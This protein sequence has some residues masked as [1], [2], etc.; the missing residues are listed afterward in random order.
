MIVKIVELSNII[1]YD[2]WNRHVNQLGRH[3]LGMY[4]DTQGTMSEYRPLGGCDVQMHYIT[5]S[6]RLWN[7][8]VLHK[9]DLMKYNRQQGP[10]SQRLN[11]DYMSEMGECCTI[12]SPPSQFHDTLLSHLTDSTKWVS[13][14]GGGKNSNVTCLYYLKDDATILGRLHILVLSYELCCICIFPT[15]YQCH[16]YSSHSI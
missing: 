15:K 14:C 4:K 7:L 8:P 16:I 5:I 10:K 6:W 11:C 3:S 2:V 13:D 1:H 9:A 12:Q